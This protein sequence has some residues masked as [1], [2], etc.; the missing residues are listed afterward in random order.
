VS[1]EGD[2]SRF[3]APADVAALYSRRRRF[4]ET[5][6]QTFAHRQG[7]RA[8]LTRSSLLAGDQRILDAGCGTG[9]SIL[10]LTDAL[11]RLQLTYRRIDAFD[12]TGAM[13]DTCRQTIE[14]ESLHSIELRQADVTR[15]RE[16]LP[17]DWSGYDLVLCASMLEHV[18][19]A[20]LGDALASL[21]E[22]LAPTGRLLMIITR[23]AFYPTRW[24]WHCNGYSRRELR[25]AL[26]VAGFGPPVFRRY[27]CTHWW[28]NVGNHVVEATRDSR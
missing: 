15:L 2:K 17:A 19:R 8:L 11:A 14:R 10:A 27:P 28:L 12:L 1:A 4:Y 26:A 7:I 21:R 18:E 23:R 6:V 5:Y 22:R 24:I 25:E 9:L 3:S 13:L 20:D 16:Q